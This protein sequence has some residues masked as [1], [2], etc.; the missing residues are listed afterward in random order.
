MDTLPFARGDTLNGI[1]YGTALLV[2]G[3]KGSEFE[4]EC[5]QAI[6]RVHGTNQPIM[7]RVVRN[8]TGSAITVARELYKFS[9]GALDLGRQVSGVCTPGAVAKPIDDMYPIGTIIRTNDVFYMLEEGPAK[10]TASSTSISQAQHSFVAAG[11]A[12]NMGASEAGDEEAII[13]HIDTA[14]TTG[15]ANGSAIVWV[16]RGLSGGEGS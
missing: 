14:L 8:N 16:Y 6:D 13:G 5:F 9:T 1:G 7:L 12:G 3:E 4:G 10:L 11:Y 2:A 15:D